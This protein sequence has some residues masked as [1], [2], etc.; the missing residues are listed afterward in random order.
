[1]LLWIVLG[2]LSAAVVAVVWFGLRAKDRELPDAAEHDLAVYSAQLE[3]LERDRERGVLADAEF[4]SARL[5]V[6]RRM[7]AA[8]AARPESRAAGSQWGWPYLPIAVAVAVPLAALGLYLWLGSP[9]TESRPFAERQGEAQQRA[10]AEAGPETGGEA[11]GEMGGET[12]APGGRLPDVETMLVRLRERLAEDPQD[13]QG[14][15]N[16]GRATYLLGRYDETIEAYE[17]ALALDGSLS[18]IRSALGEAHV[19]AADG[20]VTEAAQRAF[21]QALAGNPGDPR[22]RFFLALARD[23]DGKRRE[24]LNAL[25]ALLA[26]APPDAPWAEG[27]RQQIAAWAESLGLDPASLLAAADD[28]DPA[29][30]QAEADRLAARLA[31]DPKDYEGWIALARLRVG[32]GNPDGARAALAKGAEVYAGAPFVQQQ[33]RK[34]A[35]ALGLAEQSATA[36]QPEAAGSPGGPSGPSAADIE[37]ASEMSPEQQQEM[38]RGMVAGLAA[39]LEE[40]SDD[41]EGWRM[42]GRSYGVLGE[43]EKAAE[44]YRHVAELLPDDLAAQLDYAAALIEAGPPDAPPPEAIAR[45]ERIVA[46]EPMNR[47]ALYYLGEA[48]RRQG[49]AAGAEI[50]WQRLLEQLPADSDEHAWLKDRIEGLGRGE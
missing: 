35:A 16:L 11:G 15:V 40:E 5:E 13:L 8:D 49:D 39:R 27:V 30:R 23:Q 17:R 25:V 50:Y 12:G 6:Q 10:G 41:V 48:S 19:M 36:A 34:A 44:A 29:A 1:M 7:L 31:E 46:R 24:A 4:E 47:D 9:G 42:L 14:W 20:V 21:D 38:I 3:E 28:T 43:P 45:L 2:A 32:L 18:D 37:A 33:F 26:D 22:A